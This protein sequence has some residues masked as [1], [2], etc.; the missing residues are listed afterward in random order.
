M[1]NAFRYHL[2]RLVRPQHCI[3]A[4]AFGKTDALPTARNPEGV[5]RSSKP[6]ISMDGDWILIYHV[7][8]MRKLIRKLVIEMSHVH[9]APRKKV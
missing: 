6:S 5:L 7:R 3:C 9:V 8:H 4:D 1:A 2:C